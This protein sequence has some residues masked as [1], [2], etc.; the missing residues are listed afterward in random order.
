MKRDVDINHNRN[1][2]FISSMIFTYF[3]DLLNN[4]EEENVI[5]MYFTYEIY[6]IKVHFFGLYA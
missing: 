4:V 3:I 6:E 1:Y 5:L 2:N